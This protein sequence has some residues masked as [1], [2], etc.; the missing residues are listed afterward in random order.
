MQKNPRFQSGGGLCCPRVTALHSFHSVTSILHTLPQ[1]LSMPNTIGGMFFYHNFWLGVSL[2]TNARLIKQL[3]SR[4]L[5]IVLIPNTAEIL[6]YWQQEHLVKKVLSCS[7][8]LSR[9]LGL[10]TNLDQIKLIE[11]FLMP[12]YVQ[13]TKMQQ[14]MRCCAIRWV[15]RWDWVGVVVSACETAPWLD[16]C[17]WRA[18]RL[19]CASFVGWLTS[20]TGLG[21]GSRIWGPLHATR[22][23]LKAL[24]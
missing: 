22:L 6:A 2:C 4:T 21:T 14:Q 3:L 1:T 18:G 13:K 24:K 12:L 17:W 20:R 11:C 10:R 5:K 23:G 7:W 15:I 19:A 8:F 16:S 9:Y